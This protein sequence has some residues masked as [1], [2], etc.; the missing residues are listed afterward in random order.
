MSRTHLH[1]VCES[2]NGLNNNLSGPRPESVGTAFF[3][4]RCL[5]PSALHPRRTSCRV[6][7]QKVLTATKRED[8][9]FVW[10]VVVVVFLCF[11]IFVCLY[12][13]IVFVFLY[14]LYFLLCQRGLTATKG[15]MCAICPCPPLPTPTPTRG[16]IAT[17][18]LRIGKGNGNPNRVAKD[19][20]VGRPLCVQTW[21][22]AA[23]RQMGVYVHMLWLGKQ[24]IAAYD[25][26]ALLLVNVRQLACNQSTFIN[27]L[28]AKQ[29]MLPACA[30]TVGR[31]GLDQEAQNRGNTFWNSC[32]GSCISMVGHI[33]GALGRCVRRR[34][35]WW[36]NYVCN[37]RPMAM[38]TV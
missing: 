16:V 19:M 20:I 14:L 21:V 28:K 2:A 11:C 15:K 38:A 31:M 5:L 35:Q 24:R 1:G 18:R 27:P 30:P 17:M 6:L 9:C 34:W 37:L 23:L 4:T 36:A 12:C 8:V 22:D 3:G 32:H 33:V 7:C 25:M 13:C 26:H 29:L 10:F